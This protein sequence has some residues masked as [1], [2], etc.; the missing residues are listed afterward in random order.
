MKD[1]VMSK[2]WTK[3]EVCFLKKNYKE[4]KMKYCIDFLKKTKS[5]VKWMVQ[6]LNLSYIKNDKFNINHNKI[7]NISTPESAYILGFLWAD[8]C[9]AH[10]KK[11]NSCITI[12][13]IASEDMKQIKFL[14]ESIGTWKYYKRKDKKHWKETISVSTTNPFIYNFLLENDYDKKSLVSPTKILNKIP[15][16]L[17]SYFFLGFSDGD[18]CFYTNPNGFCKQ[19]SISGSYEQ[20]WIDLE[21]LMKQLKCSYTI[22]RIITKNGNKYS[23]LRFTNKNSLLS[24]GEYIYKTTELDNI[25]LQRKYKKF[26]EI[27]EHFRLAG[28][29]SKS[30]L[31]V[32]TTN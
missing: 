11:Y 7:T 25:G 20:C 23:H 16:N 5:N 32:K 18:G 2:K 10:N 24:F 29:N 6:K 15:D 22:K 9:I 30:K 12:L 4:K 21:N 3:E 17:K 13:K 14:F 1:R 8:G 27:K 26:L 19:Y 28:L 31:F